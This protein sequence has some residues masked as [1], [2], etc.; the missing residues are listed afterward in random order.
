VLSAEGMAR[1]LCEEAGLYA[2]TPTA[3][4]YAF[5][6]SQQLAAPRVTPEQLGQVIT[7]GKRYTSAGEAFGTVIMPSPGRATVYFTVF[8]DQA[9]GISV[10]SCWDYL[11]EYVQNDPRVKDILAGAEIL[12][13]TGQRLVIREAPKRVVR[14]GF[15]GLGDAITGSSALGIVPACWSGRQAALI[16]AEGIDSGDVSAARL[17]GYSPLV[18]NLPQLSQDAVSQLMTSLIGLADDDIDRFCQTLSSLHLATPYFSNWRTIAWETVGSLLRDAARLPDT[19]ATGAQSGS[20]LEN[21]HEL[22]P[23][24]LASLAAGHLGPAAAQPGLHRLPLRV[25]VLA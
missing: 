5:V 7:L 4:R 24:P 25:R 15:M 18:R 14:D 12:G 6:V 8:A 17:A 10:Q 16:A 2:H 20:H 3:R 9:R 11:D 13:R 19:A 22:Q 23:L 1:H 21:D